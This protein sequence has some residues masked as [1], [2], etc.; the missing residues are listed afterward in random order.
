MVGGGRRLN[1]NFEVLFG[2]HIVRVTCPPK[3]VPQEMLESL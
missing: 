2:G 3:T 1:K